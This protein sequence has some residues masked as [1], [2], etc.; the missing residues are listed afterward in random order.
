M[1]ELLQ[2]FLADHGLLV[3]FIL[4]F[5]AATLLPL[6]SE[7]LLILL[8]QQNEIAVYQLV[9]TTTL[10]NYL[11][12]C[13]NYLI[14][15]YGSDYL[16]RKLLRINDKD[17]ER[18]KQLYNRYGCWS[19]LFAWLP[20]VGDPLCLI[21]GIFKIDFRLFSILVFSGKLARYSLTAI[22]TLQFV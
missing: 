2:P 19:L 16:I 12:S 1:L 8:L 4:G 5:L 10:G 15:I 20:V 11:G 3:L 9:L 21:G 6:G 18:A 14:G 13:A 22:I 7:W 17:I